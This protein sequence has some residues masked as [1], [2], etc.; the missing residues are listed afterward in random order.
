VLDGFRGLGAE[1]VVIV[2]L[3]IVPVPSVCSPIMQEQYSRHEELAVGR[4]SC[5]T[6][7]F[8]AKYAGPYLGF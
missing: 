8:G 7:L 5:L 1:V 4:G 3:Q 2:V 6:Q